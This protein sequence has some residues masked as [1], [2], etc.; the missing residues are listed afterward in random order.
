MIVGRIYK[1]VD[2]TSPDK[3]YI[4]STTKPS[5]KNRLWYHKADYKRY[6]KGQ[7][8]YVTSFDIIKNGDYKIELIE[9][10]EVETKTD[11][12][13]KENEYIVKMRET[14]TVVNKFP[15]CL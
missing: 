14:N 8:S 6:L 2:N 15:K 7:Y 12:M 9:E 13:K 1:L 4:G 5:I 10:V 11:L 3:I